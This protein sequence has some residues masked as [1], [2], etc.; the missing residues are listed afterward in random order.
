MESVP[1]GLTSHDIRHDEPYLGSQKVLRD[2]PEDSFVGWRLIKEKANRFDGVHFGVCGEK[3]TRRLF[4]LGGSS[5][6]GDK[7]RSFKDIRN[8]ALLCPLEGGPMCASDWPVEE[9]PGKGVPA[10]PRKVAKGVNAL[11]CE[12]CAAQ[13]P[14]LR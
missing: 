7:L 2:V 8:L 9:R 13:I 4:K 14:Y 11:A 6:V 3:A 5:C 10:L 1:I 12:G